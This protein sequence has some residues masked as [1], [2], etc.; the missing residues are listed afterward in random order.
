MAGGWST[1]PNH[2]EQVQE[3]SKYASDVISDRSNS[4][5]HKKLIHVHEATRQVVAGLKYNLTLDLGTTICR[6]NEVVAE[7][8]DRCSLKE[9]NVST[10]NE[11]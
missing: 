2:D 6:K 5:Y 7:T 8:Q 10:V 4:F 1:V 3:V 11:S 9:D